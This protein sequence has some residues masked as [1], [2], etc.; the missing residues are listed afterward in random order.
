MTLPPA[1]RTTINRIT[2]GATHWAI[3]ITKR[4]TT[5]AAE[6]SRLAAKFDT[7]EAQENAKRAIRITQANGYMNSHEL[8][9]AIDVLN[10][11]DGSEPGAKMA[12][13]VAL[14]EIGGGK[15]IDDDRARVLTQSMYL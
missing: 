6:C 2:E 3:L 10:T 8:I 12:V 14:T 5:F 4:D 7:P 9:T 1:P 13:V 11:W 15:A